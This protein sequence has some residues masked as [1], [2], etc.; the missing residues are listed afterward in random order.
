MT[1]LKWHNIIICGEQTYIQIDKYSS[2]RL[3]MQLHVGGVLQYPPLRQVMVSGR[4]SM[5]PLLHVTLV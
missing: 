3:P 1:A 5:Y 4:F 2:K